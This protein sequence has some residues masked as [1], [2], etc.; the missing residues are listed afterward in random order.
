MF[1]LL[2]P[3]G[4]AR[5]DRTLNGDPLTTAADFQYDN[6]SNAS[7]V[8]STTADPKEQ[9]KAN[10]AAKRAEQKIADIAALKKL[11]IGL[12]GTIRSFIT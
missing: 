3:V 11:T 8:A 6:L 4:N 7:N 9:F 5:M 10:E 12:L 2:L 1:I